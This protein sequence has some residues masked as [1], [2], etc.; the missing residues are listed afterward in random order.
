MEN[1][2]FS[3]QEKLQKIAEGDPIYRVWARSYEDCREAFEQFVYTQPEEVRNFLMGYAECGRLMQ[4][5]MVNLAC[6]NM[7]FPEET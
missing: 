3:R 6:E 1:S 2:P 4:Q 7:V 5:R